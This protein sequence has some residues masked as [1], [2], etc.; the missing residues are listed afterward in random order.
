MSA[1]GK[2]Q[3]KTQA[4]IRRY[5][6]AKFQRVKPEQFDNYTKGESQRPVA[7]KKAREQGQTDGAVY[8][9]NDAG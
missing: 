9:A 2:H 8:K 3:Q 6:A 4:A 7:G 1:Q 5:N